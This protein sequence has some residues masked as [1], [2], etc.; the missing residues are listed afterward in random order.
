MA[1]SPR[2]H[3]DDALG[4]VATLRP[5]AIEEQLLQVDRQHH[6]AIG[7]EIRAEPLD[8]AAQLELVGREVLDDGEAVI[9][10]RAD[11]RSV[12]VNQVPPK[13]REGFL[14]LRLVEQRHRHRAAPASRSSC[15]PT[16]ASAHAR[17]SR[18][19]HP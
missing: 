16:C 3:R 1:G 17:R 13:R 7:D 2:F 19:R 9:A 11:A 10:H 8:F 5:H 15:R 4:P 12:F 6:P 14:Q 18:Y